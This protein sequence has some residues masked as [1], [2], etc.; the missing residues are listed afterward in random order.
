MFGPESILRIFEIL[1]VGALVT[2]GV[3][4]GIL[5]WRSRG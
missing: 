3:V 5:I 1:F 2:M 4:L